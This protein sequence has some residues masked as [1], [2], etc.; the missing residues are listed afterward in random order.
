M[1][2]H[3]GFNASRLAP[4]FVLALAWLPFLFAL[5]VLGAE[6][7]AL[8]I[9]SSLPK[10]DTAFRWAVGK[11]L[12]YVQTGRTGVVDGHEQQRA[13]VGQVAYIP[14]YWAGYTWRTAFY[15]RDFC[16]QADG[17]HL[18]GLAT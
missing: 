9:E 13:G 12:S 10:L 18:L 15:S 2:P 17:A 7:S 16:H 6:P 14:S 11:A 8:T 4:V 5:R 1:R 3:R